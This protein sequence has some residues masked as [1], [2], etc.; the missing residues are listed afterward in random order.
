ML[1]CIVVAVS[2][3]PIWSCMRV[4]MWTLSSWW[5]TIIRAEDVWSRTRCPI[6]SAHPSDI[7]TGADPTTVRALSFSKTL[8]VSR[9]SL[10]RVH[11]SLA[12]LIQSVSVIHIGYW[13]LNSAGW[14][15]YTQTKLLSAYS[16][17][18]ISP[19]HW[20]RSFISYQPVC[21]ENNLISSHSYKAVYD[22]LWQ[23]VNINGTENMSEIRRG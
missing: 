14:P 19:L 4:W 9:I 2:L 1:K 3:S 11:S 12:D 5:I 21:K 22:D 17:M 6:P 15:T 7:S 16:T 23:L 13:Y 8:Y 20:T 10:T 18:Q